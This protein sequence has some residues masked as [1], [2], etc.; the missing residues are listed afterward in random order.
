MEEKNNFYKL[1]KISIIMFS[2]IAL[3]NIAL[4]VYFNSKIK[5]IQKQSLTT[6]ENIV[7]NIKIQNAKNGYKIIIDKESSAQI[8]ALS[9][10]TYKEFI[11]QYIENQSNWLNTWLTI[12]SIILAILGLI[13]PI[14]F[15]KLYQ[16][17]KEEID[18]LIEKTEVQK[19]KM[20][21]QVDDVNQK[22]DE[23]SI[24]AED[25]TKKAEQ[26]S[27]E[28]NEVNALSK[29]NE[30]Y[31]LFFEGRDEDAIELIKEAY[32]LNNN[33]DKILAKY[34]E[35]ICLR[36]KDYET[37]LEILNKAI[38]I[39]PNDSLY[40]YYKAKALSGLMQYQESIDTF[41]IALKNS[42]I[43]L[44]AEILSKI[45]NTYAKLKDMIHFEEYAEKAHNMLANRDVLSACAEGAY[46]IKDYKKM[47]KYFEGLI[48]FDDKKIP[49]NYY[50][51]IEAYIFTHQ[52]DKALETIE[53]YIAK[54]SDNGFVG[55]YNDDYQKL[56]NELN[57]TEQTETIIKIKELI[58][59]LEKREREDDE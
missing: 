12:L 42:D 22:Y 28:L 8:K 3:L 37:A 21:L 24:K 39:N 31:R 52:F 43:S 55:I 23:I 13:I 20:Q 54:A 59:Q 18:R 2:I 36:N 45:A 5:S 46:I 58:E 15:M 19:D 44:S 48:S 32:E 16:D 47:V 27:K 34:A 1:L 4:N 29:Y 51:L 41:K 6:I 49:E 11:V 17:K 57:N 14:C 40:Y 30:A 26:I 35:Y 9:D 7:Q 56:M 50:H 25:V 33:N 10:K 38:E 53:I